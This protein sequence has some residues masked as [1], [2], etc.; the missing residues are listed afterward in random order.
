MCAKSNNILCESERVFLCHVD[1]D[2]KIRNCEIVLWFRN[3]LQG[4]CKIFEDVLVRS[5]KVLK[6]KLSNFR[7]WGHLYE[8]GDSSDILKQLIQAQMDMC[9]F[10][11]GVS[12]KGDVWE[13]CNNGY[14]WVSLNPNTDNPNSWF[15]ILKSHENGMQISHVLICRLNPKTEF[16][17]ILLGVS[18][19]ELSRRFLYLKS[20]PTDSSGVRWN[21]QSLCSS[22]PKEKDAN[23]QGRHSAVRRDD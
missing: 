16:E 4:K 11:K 20:G 6:W 23:G 18:F 13:K 22:K 5:W 17:G 12:M 15:Q 10:Q 2:V 9:L 3:E 1:V 19:L 14:G 8:V 21:H 7:R